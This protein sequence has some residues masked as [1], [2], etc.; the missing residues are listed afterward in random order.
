MPTGKAWN[1]TDPLKPVAP[2]DRNEARRIRIDWSQWLADTNS[3]YDHH[4]II[5]TAFEQVNA[6]FLAGRIRPLLRLAAGQNPALDAV[7]SLICRIYSTD[8]QQGDQTLN[9]RIVDK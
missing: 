5:S 9:F 8:G 1:L 6:Y 3:D 7:V 4:E 2:W